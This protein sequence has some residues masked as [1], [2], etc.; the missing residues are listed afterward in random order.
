MAV[1]P[2]GMTHIEYHYPGQCFNNVSVPSE[3]DLK[4]GTSIS[5][6][7]TAFGYH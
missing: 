6:W 4:S 5:A 1:V 7:F 3:I 2:H